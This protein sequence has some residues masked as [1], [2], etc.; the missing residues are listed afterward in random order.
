MK[1]FTRLA[2]LATAATAGRG[3]ARR[4]AAITAVAP[5]LRH[6]ALWLVSGLRGPRMV[7]ALRS[8]SRRAPAAS[9]EGVQIDDRTVPAQGAQ[10]AVRVVVYEPEGR[11]HPSGALLWIHGGGLVMGTPEQD[12]ALAG[13]LAV[14]AGIAVFSVDYRLAPEHPFPA[15]L[16]DCHHALAWL[17]RNAAE[18]GIDPHRIAIGGGS[19]GGGLAAALAQMARDRGEVPVAFQ[20]LE[21]PMLDDVSA[22]RTDHRARQALVWTTASNHY[23]WGAYLGHSPGVGEVRPYA[24]PGRSADLAGLPP[25]W[26]GVGDLDLFHDEDVSYGHRLREAGVEVVIHVEP[27]MYHGAD[28]LRA[29]APAMQAFRDRMAD[30]LRASVGTR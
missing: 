27:R 24:V 26:I 25:G 22:L 14:D 2:L 7:R 8:L 13:G 15:A 21:Y 4:R 6:P 20:L 11:E 10:P 23:G 29:K 28:T 18:L 1:H 17:H 30:A 5:E 12:H 19:A 9:V 3:L 16:D